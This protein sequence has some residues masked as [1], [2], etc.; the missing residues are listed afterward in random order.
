MGLQCSPCNPSDI[1][2]LYINCPQ[3]VITCHGQYNTET[4]TNIVQMRIQTNIPLFSSRTTAAS[5]VTSQ[6]TPVKFSSEFCP[7]IGIWVSL[8][9]SCHSSWHK[10]SCLRIT[11]V[12]VYF[13]NTFTFLLQQDVN[14]FSVK[15]DKWVS[16]FPSSF[17]SFGFCDS[18]LSTLIWIQDCG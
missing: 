2:L 9:S 3:R 7:L 14:I 5:W 17:S 1:I 11:L 12:A 10:L 13:Y 8:S 15:R 18:N 4:Y 6:L 16:L